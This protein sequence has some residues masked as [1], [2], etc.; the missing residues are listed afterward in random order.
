M[1]GASEKMQLLLCSE[2]AAPSCSQNGPPKSKFH[3]ERQRTPQY[4]NQRPRLDRCLQQN[5][6]P[7]QE[8]SSTHECKQIAQLSLLLLT[9]LAQTCSAFKAGLFSDQ[10]TLQCMEF[11]ELD[12]LSRSRFDYLFGSTMAVGLSDSPLDGSST[13]ENGPI[14]AHCDVTRSNRR[15]MTFHVV[16]PTAP[17]LLQKQ[18]STWALAGRRHVRQFKFKK[19]ARAFWSTPPPSCCNTP[20]RPCAGLSQSE[21]SFASSPSA[22]GCFHEV[23][24][25]LQVLVQSVVPDALFVPSGTR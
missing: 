5:S 2:S 7:C 21:L 14:H 8:C 11:N 22:F 16:H 17:I 20:R 6:F 13:P 18:I 3:S 12:P 10:C 1:S 24:S 25:P 9:I 23:S 15:S 4:P 19:A